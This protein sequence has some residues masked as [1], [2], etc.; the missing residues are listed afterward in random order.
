[1]GLFGRLVTITNSNVDALK[2]IGRGKFALSVLS[3]QFQQR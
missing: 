3:Q 2:G 1:M